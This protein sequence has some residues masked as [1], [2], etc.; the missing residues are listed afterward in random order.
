MIVAVGLAGGSRRARPAVRPQHGRQRRCSSS[1]SRRGRS[2]RTSRG[3]STSGSATASRSRASGTSTATSS[4]TRAGRPDPRQPRPGPAPR[5]RVRP[6]LPDAEAPKTEGRATARGRSTPT[7]TKG[8]PARATTAGNETAAPSGRPTARTSCSAG[9]RRT[10]KGFREMI[11]QL[12]ELAGKLG[13]ADPAVMGAKMVG[14]YASGCPLEQT[15]DQVARRCGVRLRPGPGRPVRGSSP[16][17][18]RDR[19]ARTGRAATSPR[20]GG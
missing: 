11:D 4:L 10:S 18:G 2:G 14:R 20:T 5:R 16:Q 1:T 6:R 3:T 19:R 12:A 17:A 9:W 8:R 13:T 7:P 15:K